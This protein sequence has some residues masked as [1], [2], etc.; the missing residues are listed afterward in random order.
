MPYLALVTASVAS[1]AKAKFV[2]VDISAGES[3]P[4]NPK[5]LIDRAAFLGVGLV[6]VLVWLVTRVSSLF[7][8][9]VL[10]ILVHGISIHDSGSWSHVCISA[11]T[12]SPLSIMLL[13]GLVFGGANQTPQSKDRRVFGGQRT[14]QVG[15]L[16]PL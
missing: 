12:Q 16:P 3:G 6:S 15:W 7:S 11:C 1:L 5:Y 2:N 14:V 9:E 8:V 4:Q 13:H 10:S